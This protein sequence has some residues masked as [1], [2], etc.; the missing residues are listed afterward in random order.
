MLLARQ[1]LAIE[2]FSL[3]LLL[4]PSYDDRI[5][6]PYVRGDI[7]TPLTRCEYGELTILSPENQF[8]KK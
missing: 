3:A 7:A 8:R 4:F 6:K 2:L 1:L 5:V